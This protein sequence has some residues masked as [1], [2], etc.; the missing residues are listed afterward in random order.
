MFRDLLRVNLTT[1]LFSAA[2]LL[3]SVGQAQAGR[4]L[5][6][7]MGDS[8]SAGFLA[9]TAASSSGSDDPFGPGNPL[10]SL[11]KNPIQ[12]E[13]IGDNKDTFSWASG[14]E[15]KSQFVLLRDFL[16]VRSPGS[17]L[18]VLNVAVTGI[19]AEAMEGQAAQIVD[20]FHDGA[21]S[22]VEYVTLLIGAND[23]CSD[24]TPDGTPNDQYENSLHKA[25]AKLSEIKQDQRLKVLV[26]SLPR[27]PD[28]G[29]PEIMDHPIHGLSSCRTVQ[30]DYIKACNPL[31]DW[32]TEA[33]HQAR[34]GIVLRKNEVLK[35][36]VAD[37]KVLYPRLDV[38]YDEH[39]ANATFEIG[40]LAIDCFHPNHYAQEKIS[41]GLWADLPWFR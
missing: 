6:G 32:S 20:E 11:L 3:V 14:D 10:Q 13:T 33:E 39:L 8:I 22:A 34:M 29:R 41:T 25:L 40:D 26:S 30:L 15:I 18:E 35:K 28:L 2:F 9:D 21:Y 17:S 12:M 27:I 5:I 7:V 19:K 36:V 24:A 38:F 31:L 37:A 4:V 16:S 1:G 23:A